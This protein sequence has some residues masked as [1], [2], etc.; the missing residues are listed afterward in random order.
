VK[1]KQDDQKKDECYKDV[2]KDFDSK[3]PTMKG[4]AIIDDINRYEIEL[5]DWRHKNPDGRNERN[6]EIA[7]WR[8]IKK[9][10]F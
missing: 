9:G 6:S 1:R 5:P 2:R 3:V 7:P 4:F 10:L 8:N